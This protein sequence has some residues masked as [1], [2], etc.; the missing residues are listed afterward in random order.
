MTWLIY[1]YVT[2]IVQILRQLKKKHLACSNFSGFYYGIKA[3]AFGCFIIVFKK[4]SR[5]LQQLSY[6]FPQRKYNISHVT[7]KPFFGVCD[8]VRH[9]PACSA[10]SN[11]SGF[12]YG[13]TAFAFGC[14]IIKFKKNSLRLQQLSYI[15]PP[16]KYILSPV[17][18]YSCHKKV[19]YRKKI[20]S[21]SGETQFNFVKK[22]YDISNRVV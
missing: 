1:W 6:I 8:Q 13:I 21:N 15:F 5:R 3:F 18:I 10:C 19:Y 2:H 12:Y 11:F 16:R 20:G 7:R 4:N 17:P 14:F 9:K 22:P